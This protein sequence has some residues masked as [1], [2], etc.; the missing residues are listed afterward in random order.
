MI[1]CTKLTYKQMAEVIE[2]IGIEIKR[3]NSIGVN[4]YIGFIRTAW[5]AVDEIANGEAH[6]FTSECGPREP[7]VR[8]AKKK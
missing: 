5:A 3:R 2:A 7:K 1:D 4:M 6:Q 8:K